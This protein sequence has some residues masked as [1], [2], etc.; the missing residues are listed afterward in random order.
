[1]TDMLSPYTGT[2]YNFQNDFAYAPV[3]TYYSEVNNYTR[4]FFAHNYS[5]EPTA[6]EYLERRDFFLEIYNNLFNKIKLEISDEALIHPDNEIVMKLNQV[7]ADGL[8]SDASMR[9]GTWKKNMILKHLQMH[10]YAHN[11]VNDLSTINV[12]GLEMTIFDFVK[13]NLIIDNDWNL[14][15]FMHSLLHSYDAVHMKLSMYFSDD[16]D[17]INDVM[18]LMPE[19]QSECLKKTINKYALDFLVKVD[20]GKL[21]IPLKIVDSA[22]GEKKRQYGRDVTELLNDLRPQIE[23]M[24]PLPSTGTALKHPNKNSI[25]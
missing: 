14:F 24:P 19:N 13:Q 15:H 17:F 22:V 21:V 16:E 2:D 3:D 11:G 12:D 4:A 10:K 25:P 9:D 1:M 8:I 6:D 18:L 20:G 23:G 5:R 7:I